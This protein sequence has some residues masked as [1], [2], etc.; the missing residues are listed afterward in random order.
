MVKKAIKQDELDDQ[1]QESFVN[2]V[3]NETVMT[4]FNIP[5]EPYAVAELAP[6]E[7]DPNSKHCK[8]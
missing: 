7:P 8:K 1:I 3:K 2:D 4:F 5:K 6:I